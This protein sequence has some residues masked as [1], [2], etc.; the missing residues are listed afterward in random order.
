M[1]Q[2]DAVSKNVMKKPP[3]RLCTDLGEIMPFDPTILRER[4]MYL[5]FRR[6]ELSDCY[7]AQREQGGE[8]AESRVVG[9]TKGHADAPRHPS[10]ELREASKC[11]DLRP[12]WLRTRGDEIGQEGSEHRH[13][14][15]GEKIVGRNR[16]AR[17]RKHMGDRALPIG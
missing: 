8:I 5:E 9:L 1:A 15:Y 3:S 13:V 7:F 17:L 4:G 11:A 16:N 14:A 6:R 12:L 10:L 2:K